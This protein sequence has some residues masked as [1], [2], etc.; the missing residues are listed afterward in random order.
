MAFAST[1][2][3]KARR[4]RPFAD[5]EEA[6]AQLLL[7]AAQSNIELAIG[8]T[9][10]EI[11]ELKGDPP[12]VLRF[13]TIEKV[14]RAMANP[15]GLSSQ[16]EALGAYSHTNRFNAGDIPDLLLS[17]LEERQVRQAVYGKLSGTAFQKSVVSPPDAV[18]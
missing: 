10:A 9:E 1:D 12:P 7:E 11:K 17:D 2:D 8:K 14:F 6:T 13:M 18:A 3:V 15:E 5:E 16:S 4:G